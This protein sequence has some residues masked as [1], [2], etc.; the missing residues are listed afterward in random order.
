MP[1]AN[2]LELEACLEDAIL[3]CQQNKNDRYSQLYF[4]RLV[5]ARSRW[6]DSIETS[7]QVHIKWRTE[8]RQELIAFKQLANTLREVQR[9]MRRTGV[10][11]FPA[12]KV[13]YWDEEILLAAV[14]RMC[15]FLR[16]HTDDID[17]AAEYIEKLE[18]LVDSARAG[19]KEVENSIHEYQRFIHVRREATHEV[20]ALIGEM[21]T[22]MRRG[23]GKK[24]E[25]YQ[26]IR[27]PYSIASDDNVLF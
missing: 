15:V 3:F 16:D 22:A 9:E 1:N 26:S 20:I 12:M 14:A 5:R 2:M 8:E 19:D 21:R 25:R 27:W 11:D 23:L 13:M 18:R 10:I 4:E 7:D 6:L 24:N 17:F